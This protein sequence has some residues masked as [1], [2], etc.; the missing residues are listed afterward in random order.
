MMESWSEEVG[1]GLGQGTADGNGFLDG[2]QA[3]LP[4]THRT[5]TET[6]GE[7]VEGHGEGGQAGVR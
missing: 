2:G 1:G 6:D 4:P 5:E 3:L 7:V